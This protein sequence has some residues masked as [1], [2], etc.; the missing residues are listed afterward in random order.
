MIMAGQL[1]NV[2]FCF[3]YNNN[4]NNKVVVVSFAGFVS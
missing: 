3:V 1:V 4:N 2:L